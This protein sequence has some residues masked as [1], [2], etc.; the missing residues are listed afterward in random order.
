MSADSIQERTCTAKP[1]VA[2]CPMVSQPMRASSVVHAD[3]VAATGRVNLAS[4]VLLP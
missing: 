3:C 4:A 1:S 2:R